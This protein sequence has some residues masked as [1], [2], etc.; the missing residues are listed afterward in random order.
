MSSLFLSD[1]FALEP[2][3]RTGVVIAVCKGCSSKHLIA[4]NLGWSDYIGGFDQETNIEE[5]FANRGQEETVSRVGSE[6]FQL[7]KNL[8][9]ATQDDEELQ[10]E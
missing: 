8:Y 7:E 5:Y 2:A 1:F 9:I 3:Y 10:L 6:A 4:D